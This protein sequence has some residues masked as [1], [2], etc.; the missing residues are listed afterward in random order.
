MHYSIHTLKKEVIPV[1]KKTITIENKKAYYDYYIEESLECGIELRGNE[2]KSIRD[3]KASIKEAWVAVENNE[4]LIKKM[5]I[6]AW[7]KSN[8]FDV[9]ENRERKLLA[10]KT[11][12]KQF[13]TAVQRGGYTLIPLKVYINKEGRVKVMIGLC[14][15]KHIY[16]KRKVEKEKQVKRDIQRI[17]K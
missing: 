7:D 14:K 5:H 11:E 9:D 17:V 16:D 12:I 1:Q 13:N 6:T 8:K 4:L 15:G 2:V 3:G 10:H